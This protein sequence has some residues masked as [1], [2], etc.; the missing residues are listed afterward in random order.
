[1]INVFSQRIKDLRK[2]FGY[3]QSD[4]A[5]AIN[6]STSKIAMWETEKRDPTNEDLVML[7]DIFE[8]STDYLLGITDI[9]KKN[10]DLK[11]SKRVL[12]L[13]EKIKNMDEKTQE[14]ALKMLDLLLE[15]NE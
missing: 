4:L 10:L 3:T 9:E 12:D 14:K 1:V 6:S 11:P 8:V 2:K 15:D 13:L 5:K 7:S